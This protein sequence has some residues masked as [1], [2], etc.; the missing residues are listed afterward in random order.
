[1][2]TRIEYAQN[3]G[4]IN[5]DYIDNAGGVASSDDE[6]NIKIL[7]GDVM[8]KSKHSMDVKKRNK[9]LESMTEE[10]ANHVLRGN[11]QQ[12][13]GISLMDIQAAKN[14]SAHDQLMKHLKKKV[15]L[16]RTLEELPKA[17]EI[18][19][20]L[21]IGKGLTRPELS[22][23]QSYAKIA[24]TDDLLNSDIPDNKAMEER[25][26]RYFPKKLSKN[27]SK[28]IL[29]HRL[30]RE[31]IATTLAGGIVNRMGPDFIRDRME[32]CGASAEEVAKAYIIVREA[33]GLRETWDNIE[34]LDGQVPA[35][36]Q[37]DAL[38]ETSRMIGR[39]VTWFLTR[40][41]RKL[42]INRDIAAFEDGIKS[43]KK[44]LDDVVPNELLNKIQQLT[45]NGI[46]NGLPKNLAHDISLMP[47]LGSACDIIRIS[48][49]NK[50]EIPVTARVYFELGDY[51]YL[52]W[53]RQKARHLPTD[54][55]WSARALEGLIDQLYT[56]QAGLTVRIL[57]DMGN[58]ITQTKKQKQKKKSK[59]IGCVGCD[60]ALQ[61]WINDRGAQAKLLEPLFNELRRSANLDISM[62]IIAEQ[63][64]RNIYGG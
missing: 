30:K 1:M 19:H 4:L 24:Y 64:L 16:S 53:M 59:E 35:S 9:L 32:K 23:L 31:I 17:T 3:G 37:L 45:D 55:Q 7:L 63:R 38:H 25:L 43:V 20:R 56:C 61:A 18:E 39:A 46:N 44:N 5:A 28:E 2:Q 58:E 49:D 34:A 42:D 12:A 33:F 6:V 41:G 15:G 62:L 48:M 36:V 27:Y 22:V 47:V 51:F 52:D 10:V 54:G 13:Q 11:Y 14:L 21:R 29:N 40:F 8:R 57:K 50:F 60:S 26:Y